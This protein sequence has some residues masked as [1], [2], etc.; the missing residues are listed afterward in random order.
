LKRS[1]TCRPVS[2]SSTSLIIIGLV[3]L[4]G[5]TLIVPMPEKKG[6]YFGPLFARRRRSRQWCWRFALGSPVNSAAKRQY[7]LS[8]FSASAGT[9][10]SSRRKSADIAACLLLLP[11]WGPLGAL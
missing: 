10:Y 8:S 1:R 4:R 9:Q 3:R 6:R 7:L 11:L 5:A 2:Q